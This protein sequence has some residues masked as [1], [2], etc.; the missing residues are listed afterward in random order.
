MGN[1]EGTV[2][3][4][5]AEGGGDDAKMEAKRSQMMVRIRVNTRA[6]KHNVVSI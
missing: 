3:T 1:E 2:P 4:V 6:R 5:G